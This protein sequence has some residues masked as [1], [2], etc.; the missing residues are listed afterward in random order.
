MIPFFPFNAASGRQISGCQ[1]LKQGYEDNKLG[2]H[3]L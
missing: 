3:G 1:L 2:L